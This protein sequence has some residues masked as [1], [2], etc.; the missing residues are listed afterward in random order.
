[1]INGINIRDID[2]TEFYENIS[3][4]FQDFKIFDFSLEENIILDHEKSAEKI[5]RAISESGLSEK[6]GKLK[7]GLQTS[8]SR[9]FDEHGVEFSGGEKQKIAL[10][11]AYYKD[12]PIVLLDEPTASLDAIAE[13][14]IY[15]SF[16]RIVQNKTTILIS[17][18][19]AST[20]FCDRICVVQ[21]GHIAEEGSHAELIARPNGLYAEMFKMQAAQYVE[22]EECPSEVRRHE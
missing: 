1:M 2:E 7:D 4:V 19:L 21:D 20:R 11:R 8:Y 5:K 13:Y 12:T 22:I 17:H 15:Q 16:H 9:S 18:R 6:L 14:E 3:A 10:A